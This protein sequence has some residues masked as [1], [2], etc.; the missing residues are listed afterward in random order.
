MARNKTVIDLTEG[1]SKKGKKTKIYKTKK[2]RKRLG[3]TPRYED[4]YVTV[5]D[6]ATG[7]A[8]KIF[9]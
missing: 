9:L 3:G 7:R 2:Y 4:S 6:P 8:T 5:R 1:K